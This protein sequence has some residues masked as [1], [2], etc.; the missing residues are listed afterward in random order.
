[1]ARGAAPYAAG[2]ALGA[3]AG[4]PFGGVGAVPGAVAGI[5]ATA[6]T[7]LVTSVYDWLGHP[8]GRATTP[9]DVTDKIFDAI[10]IRR[11]QTGLERAAETSGA[12]AASMAGVPLA[13]KI[14]GPP[15]DAQKLLQDFERQKVAPSVPVV[16]QGRGAALATKIGEVTP[17]AGPVIRKSITDTI[18]Q[19][20][21]AA[22]RRAAQ[23]GQAGN[24]NDII[25]GWVNRLGTG[26][27]K[28][29]AQA[30][31]R[32]GRVGDVHDA[33]ATIKNA[34]DRFAADKSQA[35]L[36]YG[37]FFRAMAGAKPAP[38]TN[39]LKL[40][41][42]LMGRFPNAPGLAGLFTKSPIGRLA[43]ELEP[44]TID[45]PAQ[46]SPILAGSVSG[47][48]GNLINY[49]APPIVTKAAQTIQR[50]G[51]LTIPELQ[52][53][54]SQVGYQLE[55]PSFGPDQIPR[56]QLKRLYAAVTSDM[57]N[58][59]RA[60]G[61]AALRALERATTNYGIR[62]RLIDRL[63]PLVSG[64]A[65]ERVFTKLNTAALGSGS[66]GDSGLLQA[67]K[68]V[69]S[70]QEWG[71]F[72]A[73]TIGRLGEPAT[74][75]K[76]IL[77]SAHFSPSAFAANW[78]KLSDRAKDLLFGPAKAGSPRSTLETLA[79]A[80][81]MDRFV[82]ISN[83]GE[84]TLRGAAGHEFARNAM[85]PKELG[86]L[87][88][89]TISRLGEPTPGAKDILAPA[90][91]SPSSFMT[92][93]NKIPDPIKDSLFG[94]D[95]AGSPRSDLESLAR[96]AQAQKNVGKLANV[97]RSG[98]FTLG[99]IL[100]LRAA[101]A[102]WHALTTGQVGELAGWG[103]AAGTGYGFA[104]LLTS[105]QFARWLYRMP[106]PTVI[107]HQTIAQATANLLAALMTPESEPQHRQ[108]PEPRQESTYATP[109]A[110]PP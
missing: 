23:Y 81:Q 25:R 69:M 66:G 73:T 95:V 56:A 50:G 13:P 78:N 100:G 64:D 39:T 63:E 12:L 7:D 44:R 57:K 27:G 96:V 36:D 52:E 75:T 77:A 87:A 97:S 26:I 109:M 46:T 38:M 89:T 67:A 65:T 31:S 24:A 35:T 45:I 40:V 30:A 107:N 70:P 91:F 108:L 8:L 10:G 2:A 80:G 41:K 82:N 22:G 101:E 68:K 58:A 54:R 110:S 88:A 104:K 49:Q 61:P 72:G 14:P 15:T 3:A 17:I 106:T 98:E 62:M 99:G 21:D 103:A 102:A 90:N 33:G 105:P 32:Y 28:T 83:T 5:G 84:M 37:Q 47:R 16:G 94:P 42:D 20:A 48:S 53:L 93:W 86:D 6:L 55:H 1:M 71:D 79:R 92:N 4:A 60:Q 43:E 11:P 19:T 76:D 74:G 29:A 9:Q 51:V 85:S 34:L 59:A 18:G